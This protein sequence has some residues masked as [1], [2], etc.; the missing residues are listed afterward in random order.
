MPKAAADVIA[1]AATPP[2]AG[3]IGIVRLSG[4]DVSL[5]GREILS[6]KKLPPPRHATCEKFLR[7]DGGIMDAGICLYFCAPH[8]FT[9]Q[10]VLELHGHGGAAVL[11]GVLSRCLELG[12][13]PA[14]P[15]EFTLRAYLNGKMDLAQA[16]AVADLVNA[17][18]AAAARAA[19]NS[20]TGAFSRRAAVLGAALTELRADMEAALDF[21][22]E[23]TGAARDFSARTDELSRR[24]EEFLAQCEQGA[25]LA[26]G[27]TAAIMGAP[28]AGK[29]ALFN[30][31]CGEDAAIVSATAG[32][33]RDLILRDIEICGMPVRLA[34]TAG[35]RPR[36]G[37]VEKEGIARAIKAAE[38][39]DLVL[40]VRE[41]GDTAPAIKTTA[42]VLEVQNKTDLRG[43]PAGRRGGAVYISAKTGEGMD[44]LRAAIAEIG[45]IGATEAP[46]TARTRHIAA[47][48][49]GARCIAEARGC[50][51]HAEIAAAWLA[52]AQDS[53]SSL[54]GA[55]D[56]EKLL[57]EIFSR[58]CIGK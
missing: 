17:R 51:A 29:S 9:G 44:E 18:A 21:A 1:A 4:A 13:R 25:R 48:Q 39:A 45:G 41:N 46:F 58:F 50:G 54:T 33:T 8:S 6:S 24:A 28:N 35:L 3:G 5:F 34:D 30:R 37:E 31:L 20:L 7:K 43:I 16:E 22:D 55:V 53:I 38:K 19:A 40:H 26:N 49:E 15:G 10:D 23:E 27:M 2:G 42:A 47:L 36:A 56:D 57:G 14:E 52:S 12:A 32:T 11:G